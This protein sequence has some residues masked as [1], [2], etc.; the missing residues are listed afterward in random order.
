[1]LAESSVGQN[2]SI[3]IVWEPSKDVIICK[4]FMYCLHN[5]LKLT[6]HECK[7]TLACFAVTVALSVN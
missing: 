3:F 7:Q 1:M 4:H 6:L 2:F 5:C